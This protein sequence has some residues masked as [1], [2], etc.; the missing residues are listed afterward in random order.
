MKL[1]SFRFRCDAAIEWWRDEGL[2]ERIIA[3]SLKVSHGQSY[4]SGN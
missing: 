1:G 3:V 2:A 4:G